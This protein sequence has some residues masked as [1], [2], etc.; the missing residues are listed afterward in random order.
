L[1]IS[2]GNEVSLYLD[3]QKNSLVNWNSWTQETLLRAKREKKPIFISIG[4]STSYFCEIMREESFNDEKIAKLLNEDF[5]SIKVD[6]DQMS[7]IDNYFKQVYKL[8]N[9]QY[10]SSPISIFLTE[11]L[12]PFYTAGYIAPY[13]KGN[14]LGFYELLNVVLEKYQNDKKTLVSKGRE[15]LSFLNP[16]NNKIQATK[17][18][19]GI[20]NT[21]IKHYSE[22]FDSINGGFGD[23]PKFLNSSLL[24]LLLEVYIIT[25]DETLWNMLDITLKN[26]A[27]QEIFDKEL[28]GF[29]IYAKKKDFSSPRREK[30]TYDNANIAL[31]YL[32]T[33]RIKKEKLYKDI[34]FKTVDFLLDNMSD[35]LL[36]Y[37]NFMV[38]KDGSILIDKKIIT[39]WNAMVIKTLFVASIL[40]KKY[41]KKAIDSLDRLLEVRFID[42]KLY[43]TQNIEAFLEDYAYLGLA[44]VSGYKVTGNEEYLI[45]AQTLLNRAIEKFYKHGR[46]KFSNNSFFDIY[47]DIYDLTYP[48]SIAT[49]LCLMEEINLLVESDYS[50]IIF[51]TLEFNSYNLM[52]QPLSSPKMTKALLLYLKDDIILENEL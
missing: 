43:H 51:R 32:T 41:R 39:S 49:I 48:S 35:G 47:A 30:L 12:E 31:V 26:M 34:G 15:I 1:S 9:G 23:E 8:M 46:W 2:L 36:F 6:K 5:V 3:M 11:D 20:L 25:K 33:Y 4:Y 14:V 17:L 13:P 29:Y 44:L 10:C 42:G 28:G 40:D 19:T 45:I 21:I 37:S 52:R 24:D 38:K 22:T 27:N 50:E 18:H 7:D 16:R